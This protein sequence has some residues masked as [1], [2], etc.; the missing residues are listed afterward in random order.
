MGSNCVEDVFANLGGF[1]MNKRV[2]T[3]LAASHTMS[4]QFKI[5]LLKA[6]S[7]METT[8]INHRLQEKWDDIPDQNMG[9]VPADLHAWLSNEELQKQWLRGVHD[10]TMKANE[11]GMK[12]LVRPLP[13]YWTNP[14]EFDDG[15]R[16]GSSD[17]SDE[18][19]DADD[20]DDDSDNDD[21]KNDGRNESEP[22]GD[23]RA[24]DQREMEAVGSALHA[25]EKPR[26]AIHPK[27][28]V[29]SI[30]GYLHK[31]T[32]MKHLSC[33]VKIS[34]DRGVRYQTA[35][36]ERSTPEPHDMR[37][38]EWTVYIGSNVAVKVQVETDG[39]ESYTRV[40]ACRVF[41]MRKATSG[42]FAAPK[43][44]VEYKKPILLPGARDDNIWIHGFFYKQV[45]GNNRRYVYNAHDPGVFQSANIDCPIEMTKVPNGRYEI[46]EQAAAIM[47]ESEGG[48]TEWV[49]T[50][51]KKP[52]Q[53]SKQKPKRPQN[54]AQQS[55]SPSSSSP[56]SPS[57]SS[58]SPP[59]SS[60]SALSSSSSSS[61]SSPSP[62]PSSS[63]SYPAVTTQMDVHVVPGWND[64]E[65]K[66]ELWLFVCSSKKS[67]IQYLLF[68][69]VSNLWSVISTTETCPAAF[70]IKH[71]W[72]GIEFTVKKG[73]TTTS[74]PFDTQE[75]KRWTEVCMK[76]T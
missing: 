35:K 1:V 72:I 7:G 33:G 55:A 56:S 16:G 60:S 57:S 3:I 25:L 6:I 20:P 51:R 4:T 45:E 59:A 9:E 37:D 41:R 11:M 48:A 52:G 76:A 17:D 53:K 50:S 2:Y 38:G 67:R 22:E 46:T 54:R 14:E 75:L 32:I 65:Q 70:R 12:P 44:F 61:S 27:L 34:A 63:S 39:Q 29:P 13:R 10:G 47:Q 31:T 43:G 36:A 15:D 74:K 58:S 8:R 26:D 64:K 28:W 68:D 71:K 18:D 24:E 73:T 30:K 62:S 40:Y 19:T 66:R 49:Y 23:G 5:E 21:E 42:S 69:P